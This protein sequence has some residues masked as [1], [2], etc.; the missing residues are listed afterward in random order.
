MGGDRFRHGENNPEEHLNLSKSG[1][2]SEE[3]HSG[4]KSQNIAIRA[5]KGNVLCQI[6]FKWTYEAKLVNWRGSSTNKFVFSDHNFTRLTAHDG[7]IRCPADRNRDFFLTSHIDFCSFLENVE[8][9]V[10]KI[11]F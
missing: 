4:C 10:N 9:I 7:R 11:C 2:V 1:F 5:L 8:I 3:G 6:W